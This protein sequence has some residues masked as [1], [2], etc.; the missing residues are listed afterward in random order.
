MASNAIDGLKMKVR[1]ILMQIDHAKQREMTAR[2]KTN[3]AIERVKIAKKKSFYLNHKLSAYKDKLFINGIVLERTLRRLTTMRS[4]CKR[5]KDIYIHVNN[6]QF[7]EDTWQDMITNLEVME[8][9]VTSDAAVLADKRDMIVKRLEEV[10]ENLAIA[11]DERK[12]LENRLI[13]SSETLRLKLMK[14]EL[15]KE[16]RKSTLEVLT[17]LKKYLQMA[18]SR[19]RSAVDRIERLTKVVRRIAENLEVQRD[20]TRKANRELQ[21]TIRLKQQLA[22]K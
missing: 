12:I 13:R 16:K 9:E 15:D 5:N 22:G 4:L 2:R 19:Y 14:R 21:H 20:V 18:N 6:N 10:E 7:N 8:L 17:Q 11:H 3:G 1:F